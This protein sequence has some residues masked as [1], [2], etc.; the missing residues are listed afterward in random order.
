MKMKIEALLQRIP[1]DTKIHNLTKEYRLK[2]G[3]PVSGFD[4][5]E[6]Y[7]K[8]KKTVSDRKISRDFTI[9]FG[10]MEI[11]VP[12]HGILSR[13]GFKSVILDFFFL[14]TFNWKEQVKK[15]LFEPYS[16]G[17]ITNGK[18]D[19]LNLTKG[20]GISDGVYIRIPSGI[21]PSEIK[22]FVEKNKELIASVQELYNERKGYKIA[23]LRW[24]EYLER[25]ELIVTIYLYSTKE[26]EGITKIKRETGT[27]KE[28]Y[29]AEI[30]H[31]YL[32]FPKTSGAA[33]L[34]AKKRWKKKESELWGTVY[35]QT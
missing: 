19:L 12:Y 31:N 22:V 32:G 24:S 5:F 10:K 7:K 34:K 14:K 2:L 1:V 33:V 9:Y 35:K 29:V 8:W 13:L 15:N 20:Q 16:I 27:K 3:I 28:N 26:L 25:D 6:H 30:L 21:M 11:L 18:T 17:I 23:D 4:T